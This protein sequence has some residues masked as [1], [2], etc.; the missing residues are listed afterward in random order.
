MKH[1]PEKRIEDMI[2][3]RYG[4]LV[5]E[6]GHTAYVT[7]KVLSHIFQVSQSWIHKACQAW[8][9][10]AKSKELPLLQ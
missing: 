7:Y 4:R 1:L 8:F 6:P 5:T 10:K 2:R 9:L 3:L